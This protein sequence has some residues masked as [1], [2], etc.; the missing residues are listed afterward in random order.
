M[1]LT[2]LER[3]TLINQFKLLLAADAHEEK[4]YRS[5]IKVLEEGY[6][7]EYPEAFRN[8][9]EKGLSSE[10]CNFV[11]N[12]LDAYHFLSLAWNNLP[13]KAGIKEYDVTFHGF[14]G[15]NEGSYLGYARHLIEDQGR[16]VGLKLNDYN[17]HM[18]TL[19]KYSAIVKKFKEVN[20]PGT[21][22]TAEQ[23][24]YVSSWK[25]GE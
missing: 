12:V 18:P 14:D 25:H 21:L 9:Y 10:E 7:L 19:E 1:N 11:M 2:R 3:L 20:V 15:N 4:Y 6:E 17:C 8:V 16:W 24:A 5:M 13:D 22:L 23:I